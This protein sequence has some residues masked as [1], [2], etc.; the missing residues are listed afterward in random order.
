MRYRHNLPDIDRLS[1]VAATIMLAFSLTQLISF[2]TQDFGFSF[3]GILIEIHLDFGTI[4]TTLTAFL[5][6][7]GMEWLLHSHPDRDQFENRWASL[8]H[9]ILPVLTTLVIGVGLNNFADSP[10]WWAIFVLGSLLLVTVL[11]AEYN[12][13][14]INKAPHPLATIGLTSLSFALFFLLAV[15]VA[16]TN[17]RL[18]LRVPLLGF[19]ALMVIS[20][21][22]YLRTGRWLTIWSLVGSVILAEVAM[23]L[24]YLP[25]TPI[26]FGLAQTG[27]AYGLTSFI[28]GIKESRQQWGLWTEPVGMLVILVLVGLIWR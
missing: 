18:Y 3:L 23:G 19:G 6:A 5:A 14:S 26:Q 11:V 28:S 1:I 21:S 8:R 4:I 25:V 2:Q 16:A 9:C 10:L 17:L 22:L 27:L 12:V 24:H 15:S 7:A 20:R 13:V